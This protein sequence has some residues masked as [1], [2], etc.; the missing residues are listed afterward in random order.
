MG[1]MKNSDRDFRG[2]TLNERLPQII[3]VWRE[4]N[5]GLT[6][7]Q[8]HRILVEKGLVKNQN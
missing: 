8:I 1:N 6:F 5:Q 4:K 3:G 2:F 7:N